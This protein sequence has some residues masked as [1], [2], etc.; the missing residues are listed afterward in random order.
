M[1]NKRKEYRCQCG[2]PLNISAEAAQD[3]AAG[4]KTVLWC[5]SCKYWAMIDEHGQLT[6]FR[7]PTGA[8]IWTEAGPELESCP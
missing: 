8:T 5:E 4:R 3:L 2:C 7:P 1:S 6:E